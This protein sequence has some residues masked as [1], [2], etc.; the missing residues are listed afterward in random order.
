[1]KQKV[2]R[3]TLDDVERISLGKGARKRGTGSRYVCHRLN[4]EE[5]RLFDLAKSNNY[6]V[7]KG[8]AYR[9]RRKGSP[10]CNTFRQ[11]CDALE[12][13]Y[14]VIEKYASG[15]IVKIDFSTLRVRDDTSHV[16]R[17][18]KFLKDKYPEAMECA[19]NNCRDTTK[20]IDWEVIQNK[21]IWN[22]EPRLVVIESVDR[23]VAKSIAEDVL[24]ET[25][26]YM[27]EHTPDNAESGGDETS[28]NK[29]LMKNED[30]G[31]DSVNDALKNG[32]DWNDI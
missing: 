25:F 15:D 1:M 2:Y 11:R 30:I 29:S 6:L 8:T 31:V 17:V 18:W 23:S 21:A 22:A 4:Q 9:R 26:A 12:Q 27:E 14:V 13:L 19:T 20:A 32:I 28:D 10:L 24:M 16:S 3:P 7:I 5:R